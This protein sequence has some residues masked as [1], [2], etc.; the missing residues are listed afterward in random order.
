MLA[1]V[2]GDARGITLRRTGSLIELILL[3][4][5][6][7]WKWTLS[8]VTWIK[9]LAWTS[10]VALWLYRTSRADPTATSDLL[11][12]LFVELWNVPW[13]NIPLTP[14]CTAMW[15]S[16]PVT[17]QVLAL[18]G[19]CASLAGIGVRWE[20]RHQESDLETIPEIEPF[21]DDFLQPMLH[22]CR[23][24]HTR[25]FPN[26]HSFSYSYLLVG[27][28]VGWRG[29]IGSALAVDTQILP[30]RKRHRSWFHVKGADYLE[31]DGSDLDLKAKLASYLQ[32]QVNPQILHDLATKLIPNRAKIQVTIHTSTL[33]PPQDFWATL[34]TQF[35]SG[36]CILD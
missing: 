11:A 21:D 7:I 36:I 23:T 10:W 16:D 4:I 17:W 19:I 12:L 24:T 31:R 14:R 22:P 34:L 25:L 30:P 9:V 5:L 32:S 13:K 15:C 2:A 28:P 35:P 1:A 6:K 27:I 29:S 20:Q 26:K 8:P 33:S 18:L 3:S